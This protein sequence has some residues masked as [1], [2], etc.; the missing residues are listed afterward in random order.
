MLVDIFGNYPQVR[1]LDFLIENRN[2]DHSLTD[3]A[4]GSNISRPTLYE[5]INGL[6]DLGIV[7]ETRRNGNARMFAIDGQHRIVR[8]LSG[9]DFELSKKL[10]RNELA[11]QDS[12]D[13][14]P[15]SSKEEAIVD[16]IGKGKFEKAIKSVKA[17]GSGA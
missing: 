15:L 17:L 13:A 7:Q 11:R 8:K 9:F 2:Y 14:V 4:R 6:I 10:V 1:V 3:I 12:E 5:M 16:W